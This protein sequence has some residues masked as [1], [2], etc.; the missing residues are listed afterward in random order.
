[1]PLP[2]V[3]EESEEAVRAARKLGSLAT[4]VPEVQQIEATL[5]EQAKQL[6]EREKR[7]KKLATEPPSLVALDEELK[8]WE[9][10][11]E[12]LSASLT[13]LTDRLTD[14]ETALDDLSRQREV[15]K[16]TEEAALRAI[17]DGPEPLHFSLQQH[18]VSF[19]RLISLGQR[20][21]RQRDTARC[22]PGGHPSLSCPG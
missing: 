2:R 6:Q 15:W 14:L 12:Q 22:G 9:L 5:P 13:L 16:A 10:A 8:S 4:P 3:A 20:P 21:E 19:A 1:V 17:E 18:V 11:R 7:T